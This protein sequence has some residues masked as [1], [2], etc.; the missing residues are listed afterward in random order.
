MN[1]LMS[2]EHAVPPHRILSRSFGATSFRYLGLAA[3]V[4]GSLVACGGGPDDPVDHDD[5]DS[6][7]VSS[8]IA[9]SGS[10][11]GKATPASSG[12]QGN[13]G[14]SD[15]HGCNPGEGG[16]GGEEVDPENPAPTPQLWPAKGLTITQITLNQGV[17]HVLMADDD[18]A[19]DDTPVIAGRPGIVRVFYSQFA[20]YNA[21]EVIARLTIGEEVFEKTVVHGAT[22]SDDDLQSTI[23]FEIPGDTIEMGMSYKVELLHPD[24]GEW[25]FD[26]DGSTFPAEGQQEVKVRSTGDGLKIVLVPIQY[27]A[28]NSNRLPD[29]SAAQIELHREAV[30]DMYPVRDVELTVRAQALQWDNLVESKGEGWSQLL[31]AVADLRTLDNAANDTYYYGVFNP[32]TSFGSFCSG[33]CVA[34]LG[35]VSPE[36]NS[37]S[38]AAI[39][40]GFSG[41]KMAEV[42]AHELGHNHG[43]SHSPC[44]GPKNPDPNF[45]DN[46]GSIGSWGFDIS[47]GTLHSPS[48]ARD[49]MSYCDPAWVSKFTYGALFERARF[50]N[51]VL[52]SA[53][54]VQARKYDRVIVENGGKMEWAQ[55]LTLTVP[56]HGESRDVTV[57]SDA[58]KRDAEATFVPFDHIDGGVLFIPRPE[59]AP[60]RGRV[61]TLQ[62]ELA[63]KMRQLTR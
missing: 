38:R 60:K 49:F 57:T 56:P 41:E 47:D 34:G 61:R 27:G 5:D 55:D 36:M 50:L 52:P 46:D 22:S 39:G 4:A 63:G 28:D 21:N 1:H 20:K 42:F 59:R 10:G 14:G 37:W 62:L 3:L 51:G 7:L 40:L 44:G 58:G 25:G 2:S 54:I 11:G 16:Q 29:L 8:S 15:D 30:M 12:T 26:V 9:A 13:T 53:N 43:R 33:G 19:G 35:F 6:S 48:T 23:N 17:R 24:S 32:G 18:A 31:M 45:P